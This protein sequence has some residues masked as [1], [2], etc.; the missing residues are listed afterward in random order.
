MG[1]WEQMSQNFTYIEYLKS[2]STKQRNAYIS[3]TQLNIFNIL[4]KY[5]PILT[6][7]IPIN[8]YTSSNDLDISCCYKSSTEFERTIVRNFKEKHQFQIW[9]TMKQDFESVVASFV[10]DG[11]NIE[12]FGQNTL[13]TL[14]M[15]YQHMVREHEILISKMK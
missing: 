14:Q 4:S 2:G 8:I 6:G 12:I 3:L 10:S 7:T 9:N 11:F 1:R 13:T 15:T 5:Q